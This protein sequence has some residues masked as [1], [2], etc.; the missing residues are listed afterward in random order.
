MEEY[1]IVFWR[2]EAPE[3][4]CIPDVTEVLENPPSKLP[5]S[6]LMAVVEICETTSKIKN[7]MLPRNQR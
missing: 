6:V 5:S 3:V 1:K 2:L 7:L 4:C